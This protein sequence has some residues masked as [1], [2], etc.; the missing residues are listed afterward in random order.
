MMKEA[1]LSSSYFGLILSIFFFLLAVRLKAKFRVAILNPLL[2]STIM[3]IAVLVI[4][5][6]PYE[7]YKDM[8]TVELGDKIH[9]MMLSELEKLRA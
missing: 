7:D 2:V 3:V 4:F 1:L 5:Q 9:D 8:H 6:I